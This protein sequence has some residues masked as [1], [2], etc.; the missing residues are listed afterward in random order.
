MPFETAG[1][2]QSDFLGWVSFHLNSEDVMCRYKFL[3]W[4]GHFV[5][6]FN[7]AASSMSP[8]CRLVDGEPFSSDCALLSLF[9]INEMRLSSNIGCIVMCTVVSFANYVRL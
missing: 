2:D 4:G 1:T 5:D 8:K 9:Y 7:K 3:H 6:E